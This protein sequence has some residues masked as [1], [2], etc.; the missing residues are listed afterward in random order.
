MQH[1]NI[2]LFASGKGSNIQAIL[3]Y[4]KDCPSFV[5]KLIVC[6]K[7]D[8][9]AIDIARDHGIPH[10][11]IDRQNFKSVEFLQKIISIEPS[12]LILA[13]F[14]WKVPDTLVHAFP[15]KIINIH[16][17]LLPKYG[18]KGMYG[19]HVHEAVIAAGEKESGIT[20]HYVN[21]DY[22]EGNLICQAHCPIAPEDTPDALAGKIHAL[23]HYFFPRTIE[24]LLQHTSAQ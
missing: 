1:H 2:I 20:I 3:N 15:G 12:L 11:I 7:A 14:L 24:F 9:G 10:I 19:M 6:N 4:F 13:G 16:P 22:D 21:E 5:P 23:E 17:A 18:G 8:I